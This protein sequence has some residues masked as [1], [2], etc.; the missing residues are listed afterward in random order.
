MIKEKDMLWL[1]PHRDVAD[2]CVI[3]EGFAA[4]ALELVS[5]CFW[6]FF[7][8]PQP[9]SLPLSPSLLLFI[10][11]S[12]PSF[13]TVSPFHWLLC[14]QRSPYLTTLSKSPSGTFV[15]NFNLILHCDIFFRYSMFGYELVAVTFKSL[16]LYKGEGIEMR[17]GEQLTSVSLLV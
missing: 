2:G 8:Y 3:S 14:S 9:D 15:F 1:L 5:C 6:G 7:F 12:F 10:S 11:S 13:H 16:G 4:A 17:G